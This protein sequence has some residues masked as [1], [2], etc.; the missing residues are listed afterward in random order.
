MLICRVESHN[1]QN[2][3]GVV[4]ET[5]SPPCVAPISVII[6]SITYSLL[7]FSFSLVF[8]PHQLRDHTHKVKVHLIHF[9][10]IDMN[11]VL[12]LFCFVFLIRFTVISRISQLAQ[13]T[14]WGRKFVVRDC[15][16]GCL[17]PSL[18]PTH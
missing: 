13:L 8:V 16:V 18:A 6:L 5:P 14:F 1:E 15:S 9:N 7:L 10:L 11:Q 4:H 12:L 3:C 17:A 2:G